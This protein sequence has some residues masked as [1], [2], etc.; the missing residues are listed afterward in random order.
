MFLVRLLRGFDGNEGRAYV[1]ILLLL[2]CMLCVSC[3]SPCVFLFSQ[4]KW[5]R[6]RGRSKGEQGREGLREN[7][8]NGKVGKERERKDEMRKFKFYEIV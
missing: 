4:E 2:F 1:Y 3:H 7:E 6:V 5:G 8:G